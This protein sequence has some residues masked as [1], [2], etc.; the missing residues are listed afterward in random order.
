MCEN[1]TNHCSDIL[2]AKMRRFPPPE[3][4]VK[5]KPNRPGNNVDLNH[6]VM[7]IF[8]CDISTQGWLFPAIGERSFVI[9]EDEIQLMTLIKK[10]IHADLCRHPKQRT[11][12][13]QCLCCTA[14]SHHKE[15]HWGFIVMR[16]GEIIFRKSLSFTL[17]MRL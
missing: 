5:H 13:L 3:G 16:R 9:F 10:L 2:L 11:V 15:S 8:P 4:S 6:F 12:P 17:S 1:R 7:Q 14:T